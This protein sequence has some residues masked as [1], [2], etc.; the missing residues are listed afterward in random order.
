MKFSFQCS[1]ALFPSPQD[2]R[3]YFGKTGA[4]EGQQG[5]KPG[6]NEENVSGGNGNYGGSG[7]NKSSSASQ[8]VGS[9]KDAGE[10]EVI[11]DDQHKAQTGEKQDE[12]GDEFM[13]Q[14]KGSSAKA[15]TS[16]KRGREQLASTEEESPAEP[17]QQ[18]AKKSS[19][20]KY[21]Q[22]QAT[23]RAAEED[24][25]GHRGKGKAK[26]QGQASTKG[27][28]KKRSTEEKGVDEEPIGQQHA[29]E[30]ETNEGH[31][32]P[33]HSA[34]KPEKGAPSQRGQPA[35]DAP[36]TEK[37][38]PRT[39]K[40]LV[41][42]GKAV[43]QL[44]EWLQKW[45]RVMDGEV[46]LGSSKDAP[47]RATFLS[48]P[49]GIGKTSSAK[50]LGELNGFDVVEVNASDSRT[51]ADAKAKDGIAGK[52]SNRIKEMVS[53]QGLMRGEA[54][55]PKRQMLI[56]DEVDGM[57]GGDRGGL[58]DLVDTIKRTRVP[59]VC[60]CN[61]KW[62]QKLRTLQ[63]HAQ[64]IPYSRPNKNSVKN[65]LREICQKEGL[66]VD[67]S[68]LERLVEQ[69]NNDMRV[70]LNQ[71]QMARMQSK[72]CDATTLEQSASKNVDMNVTSVMDRLFSHKYAESA[73]FPG[74][75]ALAFQD[76]DLV[77]LY[78]QENYVNYIP[79]GVKNDESPTLMQHMAQASLSISDSDLVNSR[80][81][82]QQ[83][84]SLLPY[85]HALGVVGPSISVRGRRVT[86][87]PSD[88]NF[89][90]FPAWLGK[91]STTVRPPAP[92][93]PPPD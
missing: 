3:K 10:T 41:G 79:P 31:Q 57:S 73:G 15:A 77:P 89:H 12:A 61:D 81:R 25:E 7:G 5:K 63:N 8:R 11:I 40:D 14:P 36:W 82:R 52:L 59:I 71:L 38:A 42:Q 16:R 50:L 34:R 70:A 47:A 51:K 55:G 84:W 45:G 18:G 43:N 88:R 19:R 4:G 2:I 85:V 54:G 83:Q 69:S 44:S 1:F 86:F 35:E 6:T 87:N 28:K 80:I 74:L 91:T 29:Q 53:N 72:R 27:K 22:Q 48:G 67:D 56:M 9:N 64:D 37:Y 66:A 33:A 46:Q 58:Q 78:V 68:A 93:S 65:R 26:S 62:N 60:I 20:K 92:P 90:R 17:K 23:Q 13:E 24:D 76:N 49:P 32:K 30:E 39:R 75:L 21:Q